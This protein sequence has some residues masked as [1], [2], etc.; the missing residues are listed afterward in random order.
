MSAFEKDKRVLLHNG[1][2]Y[3]SVCVDVGS[4]PM[5]FEMGRI[6]KQADAAIWVRW[7]NSVVLV[8]V[9][10][11]HEE[12]KDIDFLPLTCE[13]L[14]KTYAAGRIPGGYLKREAKPKDS[15]IL[16]AR[17]IDRSIRPL[18]PKG[19]TRELQVIATVLSHD[20]QHSTDIMALC[21]ASMALHTS[22]IPF[23]QNCGPLAGVRVARV[24]GQLCINPTQEQR[25]QSDLELVVAVSHKGIVMVEGGGNEIPEKEMIEALFFALQEGQK[26][27]QACEEMRQKLGVEKMDFEPEKTDEKLYEET[28]A[29]AFAQGL[30]AAAK[31]K[32]K[33]ERNQALQDVR[34]KTVEQMCQN[35]DD[36]QLLQCKP[37]VEKYFSQVKKDCIR[38]MI[39]NDKTRLD[40]RGY[41]DVRSICCEV[42][43]LPQGHGSALFTRGETQALVSVTLGT[44][45][46]E[47][48]IDSLSG[49]HYKR[50]LLHY[51]FP[52]FS[53]GEVRGLRGTSRREIGH[54]AL[55]ERAITSMIPLDSP[56]FPYTVRIVSEI[57]ESNGSSSM[58]TVCGST[59]SLWD[60]GIQL[61]E[62][63]AGIAMGLIQENENIVVLSDISGDEDHLGDMDFKVCGTPKGITS[64]Q[65]DIKIDSL[66]QEV[67][68]TALKQAAEGRLFILE[69]MKKALPAARS[70]VAQNAPSIIAMSINPEKIRDVIGPGGRMIRDITARTKAKIDIN[71]SGLVQISGPDTTSSQ[72]AKK[73]IEDLTREA[74]VGCVY[75]GFV[76]KVM[77]FG[78]VIEL[79]PGTE[80]FCH[81]SELANE[82]VA[83]AGDVFQEG[84]EVNVVVI[85]VERDGKIRVSRKRALGKEP[86]QTSSNTSVQA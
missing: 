56:T 39:V 65:M 76:K 55:A 38:H 49:E 73:I 79:F 40:G 27:I 46:D 5:Q 29:A 53:V 3:H 14:E 34:N 51:N 64:I 68:T 60:A 24:Q 9:C 2:D 62:P 4:T 74:Q 70:Q 22:R 81:V 26:I 15:E 19:F 80:G 17:I 11:S 78:A 50:I 71:D 77:D 32:A 54:G 75:K 35:W 45:D 48:K 16:T 59:L 58:A 84:D 61:K 52:P 82:R 36:A 18:F 20:G 66:S 43:L 42:G 57:L 33:H 85:S 7:G 67:L 44:R 86:D 30:E 28:K 6:A 83:R 23:A 12:R 41:A 63:V 8:T 69:E 25:D 47:Q 10:A 21:G 1:K 72:Q 37:I 31:T 13:Y